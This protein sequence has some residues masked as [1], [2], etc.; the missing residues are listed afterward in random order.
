MYLKSCTPEVQEKAAGLL[1]AAADVLETE[2]WTQG[3]YLRLGL[4]GETFHYC[5]VGA[6]RKVCHA[7]DLELSQPNFLA[8]RT[9]QDQIIAQRENCDCGAASCSASCPSVENWNDT[10]GR[11]AHEVIDLMKHGAKYLRNRRAAA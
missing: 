5:A 10:P 11:E 4:D 1:E 8:Y 6:L 3:D 2:G 7:W 9:L